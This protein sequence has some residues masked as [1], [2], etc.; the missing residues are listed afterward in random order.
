MAT[1]V[2]MIPPLV[3]T[4]SPFLQAGQHFLRVLA[5]ALHG[6]EQQK[7]EDAEDQKDGQESHPGAGGRA[8][9]CK[10]QI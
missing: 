4:V 9:I 5:L 6:K 2:P 7:I 8:P 10:K 3:T 1:M